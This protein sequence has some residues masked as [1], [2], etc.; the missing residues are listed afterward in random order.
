MAS[1]KIEKRAKKSFLPAEMRTLDRK[2]HDQALQGFFKGVPE[3]DMVQALHHSGDPRVVQL[4]GMLFDPNY[5]A[6]TFTHLC[7]ECGLFLGDIVDVFRRFKLD[8]GILEMANRA[9]D[10][11]R[12]TAEDAKS[13]DAICLACQGAGTLVIDEEGNEDACAACLGVGSVKVP[14]HD[15]ARELFY[16]TMGLTDRKV[17]LI[18]QQFNLS[19]ERIPTVEDFVNEAS[20]ELKK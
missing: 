11:L 18:A 14:G 12:D 2:G 19:A 4:L 17:P 6:M 9:P 5:S 7:R 15:K 20:K 13:T 3:G 10:I 16:K 1:N 8:Q